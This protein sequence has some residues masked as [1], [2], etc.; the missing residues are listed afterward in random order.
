MSE[1]KAQA[2]VA[3]HCIEVALAA[4]L[5]HEDE[6]AHLD[7]V[8]GDGDHGAG[9]ARGF[10][11]AAEA[12]TN[13]SQGGTAGAVI[14]GAGAAFSRAAGGASGALVGMYVM[15]IGSNLSGDNMSAPA[16]HH[17]LT[18]GLES[19]AQLGKAQLG[20]KTMLDT[21]IPFTQAFGEAAATGTPLAE[22]WQSALPAARAGMESTKDMIG[23]RGRSAVLK[24]RSLGTQDPGAT[25]MY[26]VLE[27]VGRVLA[28]ECKP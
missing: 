4:I 9:M 16:M 28:A 19:V 21:L 26:Y 25:S 23:K 8:A 24:E 1:M 14:S 6:L 11:A 12:A 7:S 27:A 20:D 17:A 18:K 2:T 22:T 3:A 10:R 13:E 5:E 15:M